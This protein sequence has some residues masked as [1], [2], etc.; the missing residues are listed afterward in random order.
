MEEFVSATEFFTVK[1]PV[2]WSTEEHIPGAAFIM[3]NS[4]AALDRYNS[5]SAVESGDL[6]L[7]VGFLPFVLLKQKELRHLDI[8]F[9][10]SPDVFL[11]S[12]LPMFHVTG[13]AATSDT[14][15]VPLSDERDAGMLTLSDGE[16]QGMILMFVAGDG[17]IALV[18]TAG[19][20]GELGEFQDIAYAIAAEVAFSGAQNAL[21]GLL[22]GG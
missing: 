15:L 11:Q 16:R 12:L 22:L 14:E 1:V 13:D 4:E 6:V 3:A 2:G 10:S 17:V 21:Y 18:S 5:G 8:Q 19:F 20:P 7:N 9:E